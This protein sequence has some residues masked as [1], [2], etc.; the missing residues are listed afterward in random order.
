MVTLQEAERFAV[1][2]LRVPYKAERVKNDPVSLLNEMTQAFH[3][4]IPFQC[5]SLLSVPAKERGLPS[6]E[7]MKED[8]LA[9]RGG[10]CYTLNAFMKLFLE[11]LGY[12]AYH[13]TATA[14]TPNGHILTR[15]DIEGNLFLVE[16]G[17]GYPTFEVVPVNFEEESAVYK[18]SVLEY[19]FIKSKETGDIIRLHRSSK[20]REEPFKNI[21]IIDGWWRFYHVDLTPRHLD[22]FAESMTKVYTP[23]GVFHESLRLVAYPDQ[24]MFAVKDKTQ[25]VQNDCGAIDPTLLTS[26]EVVQ[27][28]TARF[29]V[30][31]EL[32][33]AALI[34]LGWD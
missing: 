33:K 13:V 19:K 1:E 16:V 18:N 4:A 28:I 32:T 10:V 29:P 3:A 15:V 7:Q 2:V 25:L 34:N 9:G 26:D 31:T 14:V 24:K 6:V 12:T 5:I 17:C 30:L 23:P 21:P 27:V 11:A 20:Y 22:F 8:M